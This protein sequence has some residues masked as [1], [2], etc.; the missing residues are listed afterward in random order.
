MVHAHELVSPV[1][2]L[3]GVE[4]FTYHVLTHSVS[5]PRGAWDGEIMRLATYQAMQL[6]EDLQ[7]DGVVAWIIWDRH[8]LVY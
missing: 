3:C 5:D 1:E 6:V 4:S 8:S 2:F 7:S